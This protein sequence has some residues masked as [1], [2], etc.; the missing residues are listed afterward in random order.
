MPEFGC[1][2]PH[3]RLTARRAT[4]IKM[5]EITT[6]SRT[7]A[8]EAPKGESMRRHLVAKT[9]SEGRILRLIEG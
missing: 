3:S 8:R 1:S 7:M 6:R 9:T 2:G 5:K 4:E